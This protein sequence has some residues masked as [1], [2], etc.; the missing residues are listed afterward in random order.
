MNRLTDTETFFEREND[1]FFVSSEKA[2]YE[3]DSALFKATLVSINPSYN[4]WEKLVRT[5]GI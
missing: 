3:S 5:V 4:I 2:E 1:F